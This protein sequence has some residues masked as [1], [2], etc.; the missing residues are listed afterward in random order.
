MK[1]ECFFQ[2]F[3]NANGAVEELKSVGFSNAYS[4]I[5]DHLTETNASEDV[6]GTRSAPRLSSLVLGE[7]SA[8]AGPLLAASPMVSGMGGFEEIADINCRVVVETSD[9]DAHKALDILRKFGGEFNSPNFEIPRGLESLSE[10][11]I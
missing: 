11:D 5:N 2:G 7:G 1:I 9:N 4:D 3:K 6:P 10:D 8:D